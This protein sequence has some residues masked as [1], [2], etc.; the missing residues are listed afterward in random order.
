MRVLDGSGD[1]QVTWEPER[2]AAGDAEA[3]AALREAERIFEKA[4]SN[5]AQAFQILP[6]G[7]AQR[8]VR[9]D[10]QV[11]EVLVIPAMVGG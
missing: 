9:F 8:M 6:H 2:A 7:P 11:S 3:Q 4:R 5:G 10:P 1:K